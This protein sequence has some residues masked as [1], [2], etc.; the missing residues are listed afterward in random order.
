MTV[1]MP[2]EDITKVTVKG[3]RGD[4]YLNHRRDQMVE[5]SG[6]LKQDLADR[7]SQ[8]RKQILLNKTLN[9]AIVCVSRFMSANSRLERVK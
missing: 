9:K 7:F 8:K 3:D 6:T 2:K 1:L 4:F 5:I